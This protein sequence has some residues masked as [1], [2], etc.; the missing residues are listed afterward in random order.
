MRKETRNKEEG[1]RKKQAEKKR[2]KNEK[3]REKGYIMWIKF[4]LP[5]K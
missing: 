4:W 2:I 1:E 3:K 5:L